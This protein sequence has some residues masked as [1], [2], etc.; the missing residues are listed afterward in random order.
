MSIV[1]RRGVGAGR[2]T[3]AATPPSRTVPFDYVFRIPITGVPG[4]R[5]HELINVST[6]GTFVTTSI[7][8]SLEIDAPFGPEVD[9]ARGPASPP[10]LVL[11]PDL[12]PGDPDAPAGPA[13]RVYGSRDAEVLLA[14]GRKTEAI[15]LDEIDE[16]GRS[17]TRV[18]LDK[19]S[20]WSVG[21]P[22][23]A[24]PVGSNARAVTV[25]TFALEGDWENVA[26]F[27]VAAQFGPALPAFGASKFEVARLPRRFLAVAVYGPPGDRTAASRGARG[28]PSAR[29]PRL[30]LRETAP[31]NEDE[32]LRFDLKDAEE[33]SD[34]GVPE[35]KK[36]LPGDTLI[37]SYDAQDYSRYETTFRPDPLD[38][39]LAD[40]PRDALALGFRLNPALARRLLANGP[41]DPGALV[42]P[43][44]RCGAGPDDFSFLYGIFDNGTG[45]A[46][47]NEMIHNIAGLGTPSGDRPFRFL[48]T[49]I[50]LEPRTVLRFEIEEL[51]GGPGTLHVDFQGYKVIG[52]GR[53]RL[54]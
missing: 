25:R 18:V 6:V 9:L 52:S 44:D 24:T 23:T 49:P 10:G 3:E 26:P 50:V 21:D 12:G 28:G 40:I 34:A 27:G 48:P 38:L 14:A 16:V 46:Y 13:I 1:T 7:G 29:E 54:P 53:G 42:E 51:S 35:R 47:Q 4:T 30:L 41:P 8:Y 36:V 5:S 22:I 15:V 11:L 32:I 19:A 33:G 39:R 37:L 43:F 2:G 31:N 17:F 45:R 20:G